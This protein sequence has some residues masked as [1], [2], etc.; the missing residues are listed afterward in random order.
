M[1]ALYRETDGLGR[2][3]SKSVTSESI[4][5]LKNVIMKIT[6]PQ[7]PIQIEFYG[8]GVE[9]KFKKIAMTDLPVSSADALCYKIEGTEFHPT[10]ATCDDTVG[11][12]TSTE[13][14]Q[15]R[16]Q[17]E[18]GYDAEMMVTYF[19]DL[20]QNG[21]TIPVGKSITTGLINGLGGKFRLVTIP[22]NIS[23][24]QP[25]IISLKGNATMKNDIWSTKLPADFSGSPMPCFKV[26]GTLFSPQG[27]SC[28]Q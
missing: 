1:K 16:F 17:N 21:V 26:W 22:K 8:A 20:V 14:R 25:I 18:A 5:V 7:Q 6:A 4:L 3:V 9:G 11:D 24:G 27:G 23:K 28:N 19:D 12:T 13:T 10:L 15:I 2:S